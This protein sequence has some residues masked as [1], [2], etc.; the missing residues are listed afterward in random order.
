MEKRPPVGLVSRMVHDDDRMLAIQ[1]AMNRYMAE[2]IPV[3]MEWIEE[4][5]ALAKLERNR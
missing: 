3:P 2:K 4:Y 1:R 5:N